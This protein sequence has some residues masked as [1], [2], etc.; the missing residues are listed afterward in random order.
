VIGPRLD[1][2]AA[3]GVDGS[4]N[5][6]AIGRNDDGTGSSGDGP[7]PD[8]HDHRRAVNIGQRLPRQTGSLHSRG[9]DNQTVCGHGGTTLR[10]FFR[11][12]RDR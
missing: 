4:S 6:G 1:G 8:M 5:L 12:F 7:A 10:S 11:L 3:G 2:L 9:N